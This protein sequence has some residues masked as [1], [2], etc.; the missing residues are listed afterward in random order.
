MSEDTFSYDTA[1]LIIVFYRFIIL[2][3]KDSKSSVILVVYNLNAK[4]YSLLEPK[5]LENFSSYFIQYGSSFSSTKIFYFSYALLH[6][7]S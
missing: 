4:L 3:F 7:E 1:Q 6:T 5:N 2:K